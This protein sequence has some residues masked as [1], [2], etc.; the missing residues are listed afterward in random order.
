MRI[1]STCL[2]IAFASI[3]AAVPASATDL[4][5]HVLGAGAPIANSTVTLWAASAGEP[6][7]LAQTKSGSD[8]RF[9]LGLDRI[10][11]RIEEV[12]GK[13][14]ILYLVA[15]GGMAAA[16]K[17]S[18]D[19]PAIGLMTVLND[20]PPSEVVINELTTVASAFTAARFIK[21]GVDLRQSTRTSDRCG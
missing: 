10:G 3:L 20:K 21:G 11:V 4:K 19:N 14:V 6:K 17:G 8:G 16:A 1:L 9:E 7:Q 13:D 12:I 15:K 18:N 2:A 5:G